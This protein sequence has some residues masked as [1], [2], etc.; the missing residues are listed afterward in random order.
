MKRRF[1]LPGCHLEATWQLFLS[2]LPFMKTKRRKTLCLSLETP[3][4]YRLVRIVRVGG[5]TSTNTN[6]RVLEVSLF[7]PSNSGKYVAPFYYLWTPRL[8]GYLAVLTL[9]KE[10]PGKRSK[11]DVVF[12]ASMRDNFHTNSDP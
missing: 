11:V 6:A 5:L 8:E 2:I 4:N 12:L 10:C 3:I 9:C 1:V 7:S